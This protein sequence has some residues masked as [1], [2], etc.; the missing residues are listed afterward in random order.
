MTK[1][2]LHY[3][4]LLALVMGIFCGWAFNGYYPMWGNVVNG[5]GQIFLHALS[6]IVVPLVFLS[7]VL[8]ISK[9]D[10]ANSMEG[11]AK[12]TF[13]Y[14][15]ISA[16]VAAITATVMAVLA[17]SIMDDYVVFF[18]QSEVNVSDASAST[19][20][21]LIDPAK[22]KEIMDNANKVV[23]MTPMDR[24]V[25]VVP[26]NIFEA[27]AADNM[28]PV[29]F[30]SLILGYFITKINTDRRNAVNELFESF[31]DVIIRITNFII[32]LSPIGTFAIV[33]A[34]VGEQTEKIW[35]YCKSIAFF[36]GFVWIVL[37]VMGLFLFI[38][39]G[40][41][42][43]VPRIEFL[44]KISGT[45]MMAFSTRSSYSAMPM[46]MDDAKGKVGVSDHVSNFTIP[47][48]ITFNKTGTII[49]E[50]LAVLFVAHAC[51]MEMSIGQL[52][53]L[54]CVSIITVMAAP[55]I[56]MAGV[57]FL[58]VLLKTMEFEDNQIATYIG[59]LYAVDFLCDMPKTMLN[60]YSVF[61][62]TIIVARCEGE[63]LHL[64]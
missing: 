58:A 23:Q 11:V 25:S 12:K 7:T 40:W 57:V 6:M 29:L 50:C 35:G 19:Y 21:S 16:L 62:G 18:Q 2:A 49:Y 54:V 53:T 51:Q 34:L 59:L 60:V 31:Q 24:L 8:S 13:S 30:F 61:C 15:V 32:R 27:F 1:I 46:M 37:I 41:M 4:M 26:K 5:I 63:E 55:S 64:R 14:F 38:V 48:G 44:R 22:L 47:L 36:I 45:L 43:K 28:M 56:P 42:T 52:G 33:M 17:Y 10:G 39:A 9:M 20:L 3:Q